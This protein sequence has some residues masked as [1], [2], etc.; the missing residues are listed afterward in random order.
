M[1]LFDNRFTIL[2][3]GLDAYN[4]RAEA[5]ANNIA[6]V[7]TPNYKRKDIEF[8]KYLNTA[9]G[10]NK[11]LEGV[12]T[13]SK[14]IKINTLNIKEIKPLEVV[15]KNTIMRNDKNNVDI[16]KEKVEQAKNNIRYQT[17][18]TRISQDFTLLKSVIKSK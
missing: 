13:N 8:E 18:I 7:N 6:N 14:H 17:A 2:E 9:L 3:K 5:I 12:T 1:K 4:K 10:E 11:S 15:E 16:E